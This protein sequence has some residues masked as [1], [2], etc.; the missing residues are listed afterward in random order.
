LKKKKKKIEKKKRQKGSIRNYS[1][2]C[3]LFENFPFKILNRLFIFFRFDINILKCLLLEIHRMKNGYFVSS[4][5]QM[6]FKLLLSNIW[7]NE[8]PRE[9][10][11]RTLS[12]RE[13]AGL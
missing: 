3:P 6:F 12:L 7:A 9:C 10:R 1:S 8:P 13:P 5:A 2:L 4:I 11:L